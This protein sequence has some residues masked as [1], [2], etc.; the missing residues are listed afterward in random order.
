MHRAAA[1]ASSTRAHASAPASSTR[2]CRRAEGLRRERARPGSAVRAP[3]A[4]ARPAGADRLLRFGLQGPGRQAAAGWCLA[5]PVP[6]RPAA[7]RRRRNTLTHAPPHR[8]QRAR[9]CRRSRPLR[10][11]CRSGTAVMRPA[12]VAHGAP[13]Q[14]GCRPTGPATAARPAPRGRENDGRRPDATSRWRHSSGDRAPH[15]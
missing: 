1:A 6:A 12:V 9:W 8:S 3:E 13:A 7:R 11:R 15:P 14:H 5:A 2:A 4:A 10:A